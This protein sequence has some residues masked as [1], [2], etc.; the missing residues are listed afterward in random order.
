MVMYVC[1]V[2]YVWLCMYVYSGVVERPAPT[3]RPASAGR[4]R[5]PLAAAKVPSPRTAWTAADTSLVSATNTPPTTS[6]HYITGL[7][8]FLP[9][10]ADGS[11]SRAVNKGK[12]TVCM[13]CV[14]VYYVLV[15]V[16][17]YVSGGSSANVY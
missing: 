6:N 7:A 15:Y 9:L 1:L 12:K 10:S 3:A 11:G 4:Q 16:M 5:P 13:L 17:Y 8:V 14:S 2:I